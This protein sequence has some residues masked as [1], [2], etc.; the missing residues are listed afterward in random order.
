LLL[1]H[2]SWESPSFQHIADTLK[3]VMSGEHVLHTT[4]GVKLNLW[5]FVWLT[6]PYFIIDNLYVGLL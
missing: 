6:I 3:A 5:F 1:H 2:D 4:A